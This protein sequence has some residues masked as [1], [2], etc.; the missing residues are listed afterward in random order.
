M[1][2]RMN[3]YDIGPVL[4]SK[5]TRM[6]RNQPCRNLAKKNEGEKK[7]FDRSSSIE[8]TRPKLRRSRIPYYIHI[9]ILQTA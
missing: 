8:R 7:L 4:P 1:L 2:L 3:L 6:A 9:L 5:P